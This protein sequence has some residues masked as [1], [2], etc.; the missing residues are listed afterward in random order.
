MLVRCADRLTIPDQGA[1]AVALGKNPREEKVM[2]GK[3]MVG[4]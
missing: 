4:N 2:R 1:V 3:G